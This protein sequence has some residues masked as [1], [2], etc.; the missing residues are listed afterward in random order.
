MCTPR[1]T[2]KW[3]R[4]GERKRLNGLGFADDFGNGFGGVLENVRGYHCIH[5]NIREQVQRRHFFF[6]FLIANFERRRRRR[7][8]RRRKLLSKNGWFE[9]SAF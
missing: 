6:L 4:E 2:G 5:R 3:T 9:K 7:R 8:R 1:T